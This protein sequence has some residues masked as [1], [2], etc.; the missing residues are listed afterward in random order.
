MS[1]INKRKNKRKNKVKKLLLSVIIGVFF[2]SIIVYGENVFYAMKIFLYEDKA[3]EIKIRVEKNNDL[4]NI[5]LNFDNEGSCD[6]YLRGFVFV[7]P[8]NNGNNGTTL[9][10]SSVKINYGDEDC[11]FVGEDNY[12]YYTKPLKIGNRTEK[13][14]VESM[15]IN[16]SEED[17][18]MLGSGE[19]EMDIVMEAV[20]VNNFA[21]KYEWDMGNIGLKDLFDNRSKQEESK[22]IEKKEV[23]KLNFS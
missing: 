3:L 8:N 9:S 7:Y 18:M 13:P 21:Y 11:W 12:V 6:V 10:N 22:V 17:K 16:L 1:R 19:L 2:C 15:E 5:N 14:M 20:Q 23:I 4:A